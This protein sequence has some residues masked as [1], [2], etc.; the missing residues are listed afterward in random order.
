MI[1]KND[2]KI[3]LQLFLKNLLF[4]EIYLQKGMHMKK[5]LLILATTFSFNAF[6]QDFKAQMIPV[7]KEELMLQMEKKRAQTKELKEEH[8]IKMKE[9]NEQRRE[10]TEEQRKKLEVIKQS[11]LEAWKKQKEECSTYAETSNEE[12]KEKCR[13]L[14]QEEYRK[15]MEDFKEYKQMMKEK[16]SIQ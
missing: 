13:L 16:N 6:A 14:K 11:K 3:L 12:V 7:S 15:K 10:L 5:I 2:N 1:L 4:K 9:Q 8:L